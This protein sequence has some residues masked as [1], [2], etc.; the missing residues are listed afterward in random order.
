LIENAAN[1]VI[2]IEVPAA[3]SAEFQKY[4]LLYM[5]GIVTGGGQETGS[6]Q[7][8]LQF[9]DISPTDKER[10]LDAFHIDAV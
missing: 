7:Q 6:A 2:P 8:I 5:L 9:D 1:V 4:D 10:F 3:P